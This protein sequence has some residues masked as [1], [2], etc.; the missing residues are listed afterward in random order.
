[1]RYEAVHADPDGDATVETLV[2]TA[3]EFGFDGVVVRN[4]GDALPEYDAASLSET[5][6][7]DV[8]RGV[9]VRAADPSR[10]SGFVG[11]HRD[12]KTI[13]AVHGGTDEM[14]RFAVEQSAVDVLAHPMAGDGN[15]NQVLAKAA[16]SNDVRVE[17]S[18]R[19]VVR[20]EGGQ[21]V[22]TLRGLRKL[23]DIVSEYGVPYVVSVDPTS[24]LHLR[25]PRDLVA[26]GETVGF[27][28]D[29]VET[30]LA[31]WGVLAERN[32]TRQSD[33]YVEPGVS[34]GEYEDSE[35]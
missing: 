21:R 12:S 1:M 29:V 13:V 5:Y 6:G 19:R 28:A 9:E 23:W 17:F 2:K 31:E 3:S 30:G 7:I 15:F 14:N 4:H 34:L 25:A 11:N 26:L 27:D 33:A 32:R 24:D 10:A 16:V 20:A 18:F 8:V 35:E 22:K